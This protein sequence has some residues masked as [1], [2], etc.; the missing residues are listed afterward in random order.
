MVTDLYNSTPH[1]NLGRDSLYFRRTGRL[2]DMSIFC[3]F[4]CSM[5][6]HRGKDLVEH[7][8]LAPRGEKGVCVGIDTHFGRRAFICYSARA[9]RVYA[10]RLQIQHPS[11]FISSGRSK[12][13]WIL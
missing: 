12:A 11:I 8:K 5:V 7:R 9:N 3:P 4:G 10:S 13:A 6:M 2:P 1:T